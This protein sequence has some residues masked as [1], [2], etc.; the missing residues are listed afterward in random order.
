MIKKYL[1]IFKKIGV[2]S[3]CLILSLILLIIGGGNIVKFVIYSEYYSIK[4]DICKNPGLSDGFVCQGICVYEEGAKILVSGYMADNSPSRIYVTDTEN[5]SY[6]VSVTYGSGKDFTGHS[7]GIAIS[8]DN[9]YI[10]SGNKIYA[11]PLSSILD[12]KNGDSVS[13]SKIIPVNNGASFIYADN[14]YIYVGE[15]HD[16]NY[17]TT[18]HPYETPDGTY[19]AIVSRYPVENIEK[20]HKKNNPIL[21][22]DKIYSIRNNAQGICFTPEGKV[23][24]STSYGIDDTVYYVY[25]EDATS[26]SGNILD[27]APVYY[28]C[29]HIKEI[30]APAMGEDIDYYDGQIITLSESASNKYVIGKFFFADKIVLIDLLTLI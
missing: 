8:D 16:G 23:V 9:A 5:N 11:I 13:I 28:L 27:G 1:R 19:Y 6:Y 25:N 24:L 14:D 15:Y 10:A 7:G 17:I 29:N 30:K 26:N 21:T 18:D 12:A 4:T 20:Y 2:V 3:L 22:P